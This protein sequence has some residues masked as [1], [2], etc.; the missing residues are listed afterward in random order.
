MNGRASGTATQEQEPASQ[1]RRGRYS[2]W[3]DALNWSP[4]LV[5]VPRVPRRATLGTE[6]VLLRPWRPTVFALLVCFLVLQFLIPA[7]LVIAGM[8]AIGRPAVAVGVLLLFLWVLAFLTRDGLPGGF[9]P[10]RWLIGGFV[11][12]Q[13][14][15]YVIGHDRGLPAIEASSADRWLIFVFAMAGLAL[16]T[17]DGIATRRNLDRILMVLVGLAAVM[18]V[19][20]ALQFVGLVNLVEY[21][22]IPGLSQN[23]SLVDVSARGGPGFPRVASTAGHYIEFGVVLAMLLP[24]ALHYAFFATSTR[25]RRWLWAAA[26]IIAV[27]IPFSISRSAVLAVALAMFL[28]FTIWPWRQRY[29]ALAIG[30]FAT[31]AF[32]AVQPGVLGTIRGLFE[33]VENDPSV[34]NRLAR[35]EYVMDLWEHRPWLGR[36][37]GSYVVERYTLLDNQ[38]YKTLIEGGVVGLAGLVAFFVVPYLVA[39][40]IRLRGAGQETRHLAQALAVVG[41][42]GLLASGTFDSF[43]FPTFVGVLFLVV[44]AIGA[45]WRLDGGGAGR[46]PL[47][48][49]GPGDKFVATPWMASWNPTHLRS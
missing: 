10:V 35:T 1:V 27:G 25:A 3:Q 32:H 30:L 2:A 8:G 6:P 38:L 45:L 47:Q 15:G 29:N 24:L 33:N 18:A 5:R 26:G 16:A 13:L 43:F 39:R 49:A 34:Q 46:R 19:I 11:A 20:G 12:L 23:A 14:F 42:V 4:A 17:A 40:S 44:G 37:A 28:M 36:G 7:R 21:I 48:P 22:R 41:P 9:Q 31:I